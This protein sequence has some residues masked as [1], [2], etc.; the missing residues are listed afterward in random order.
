MD[1]AEEELILSL[2]DEEE[3]L[4]KC[5]QEHMDLDRR[6]GEL[7][8]KSFLSQE[9]EVEETRL[10]KLKLLRKDQIVAIL[11]RYRRKKVASSA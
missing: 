10:K 8:K 5:Y 9:E 7:R 3:D 4:K 1:K 2:I 11:D 6:L